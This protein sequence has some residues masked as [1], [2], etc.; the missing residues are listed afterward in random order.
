MTEVRL[1]VRVVYFSMIRISTTTAK[2]V[3]N[4]S[5]SPLKSVLI[6]DKH[7]KHTIL[8]RYLH[9]ELDI[10]ENVLDKMTRK[11]RILLNGKRVD[12]LEEVVNAGDKIVV[13]DIDL[14]KRHVSYK[15]HDTGKTL[16][17][18]ADV[19]I[20]SR[21][22]N[23]SLL[24]KSLASRHFLVDAICHKY[25]PISTTN[26]WD[27]FGNLA[28][29][30]DALAAVTNTAEKTYW[31]VCCG[32]PQE[33]AGRLESHVKFNGEALERVTMNK[34]SP[35]D[36][37]NVFPI[38]SEYEV[39][40]S[41]GDRLGS[42]VRIKPLHEPL[43]GIPYHVTGQEDYSGIR[44]FDEY[45]LALEREH[46]RIHASSA[47][48]TP[49]LGDRQYGEQSLRKLHIGGWG[50]YLDFTRR[51]GMKSLTDG[52]PLF[53]HLRALRIPGYFQFQRLYGRMKVSES[54]QKR[55]AGDL[56]AGNGDLLI[57]NPLP[58]MWKE[59]FKV[60]DIQVPKV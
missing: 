35:Y 22:S 54:E 49:I 32:E 42:L 26:S 39:I 45:S 38:K 43:E 19:D 56:F 6:P 40:A 29:T 13:R 58:E 33:R 10:P 20:I 17:S 27:A 30:R 47:L 21:G 16:Y 8:G 34:V 41:I 11:G 51:G 18:D 37:V 44:E 46:V 7:V 57:V 53:L 23:L 24:P 12:S 31:A 60:C 1:Q 14:W 59:L 5:I 2:Q 25:K 15:R 36:R 9:F 28:I 3:V 48:K 52:M 55:Q 50:H 4:P